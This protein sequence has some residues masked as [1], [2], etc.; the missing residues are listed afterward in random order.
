MKKHLKHLTLSVV[1]LAL[2]IG[3]VACAAQPE[4]A[5]DTRYGDGGFG[6]ETTNSERNVD[7]QVRDEDSYKLARAFVEEYL[8]FRFPVDESLQQEFDMLRQMLV[9]DDFPTDARVDN[10]SVDEGFPLLRTRADILDVYE[11]LEH[12]FEE[13]IEDGNDW[14]F[15][16]S[17]DGIPFLSMVIED[18]GNNEFVFIQSGTAVEGFRSG[19]AH[20]RE[21]FPEDEVR[22]Y[23]NRWF[24]F[25]SA[26]YQTLME[27]P[28][29]PIGSAWFEEHRDGYAETMD[30]EVIA[31][32]ILEE[33]ERTDLVQQGLIESEYGRG[34][35]ADQYQ[36]RRLA[37]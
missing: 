13:M 16:I 4:P 5:P 1:F 2:V 33:A 30:T 37:Q 18:R 19:V 23:L 28:P 10:L 20:F 17:Y 15:I 22:I 24:Y 7:E 26:D 14:L 31:E 36:H 32:I 6:V 34:T 35:L 8:E 12:D 27:V 3:L 25:L 11:Q 29:M 9:R 21:L